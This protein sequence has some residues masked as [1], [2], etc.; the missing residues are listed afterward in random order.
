MRRNILATCILL[1]AACAHT[2]SS[3]APCVRPA[4]G[5]QYCLLPP[6]AMSLD[7]SA[8]LV[9]VQGADFEQYFVSRIAV[10]K[11]EAQLVMNASSLLGQALFEIRYTQQDGASEIT[12]QPASAPVKA[13]WLLA[14]LQIAEADMN[15]V[16]RSLSGATI[17][18]QN[19]SRRLLD[20][21]GK[22]VMTIRML[23][24]GKLIEVPSQHLMIRI[25]KLDT[26]HVAQ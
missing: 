17:A 21:R 22:A 24:N 13:K 23:A 5:L 3:E 12:V 1:L 20:R 11:S 10:V 8:Q 18:E 2:G 14:M 9:H 4:A 15:D 6:A 16:R 26:E 25:Q 19:G 7:E